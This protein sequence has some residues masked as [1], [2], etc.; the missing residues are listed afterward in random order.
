MKNGKGV[1][2]EAL[3]TQQHENLVKDG[4]T[5]VK[6][7]SQACTVVS[8]LIATVMFTAAFTIPGGN[9]QNTGLPMFLKSKPFFFFIVSDSISLFASCTSILMF[10]TL[11]TTRYAE[12]DFLTSLPKKLILGLLFL[13]ISIATMLAAYCSC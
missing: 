2:P 11:L 10:F 8:T 1:K 12:R 9:D 6:E 3:F 13:F 4:E 5:W 7:A